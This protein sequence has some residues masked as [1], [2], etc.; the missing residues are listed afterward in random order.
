MTGS[1]PVKYVKTDWFF[2][3]RH[4]HQAL[5]FGALPGPRE[6]YKRRGRRSQHEIPSWRQVSSERQRSQNHSAVVHVFSI[7]LTSG[8]DL[9]HTEH[10]LFL[11]I[12]QC[13]LILRAH[14]RCGGNDID[15]LAL[16]PASGNDG[17]QVRLPG[18]GFVIFARLSLLKRECSLAL[19]F[20]RVQELFLSRNQYCEEVSRTN[21][22]NVHQVIE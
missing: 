12:K 7:A 2:G 9:T 3:W 22:Q 19:D 8:K 1:V 16:I 14:Y 20:E 5:S 4:E 17:V 11:P 18:L 15:P 21:R 10:Q 6:R 13:L